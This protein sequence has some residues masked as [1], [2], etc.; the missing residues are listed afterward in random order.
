MHLN[1]ELPRYAGTLVSA[2]Q[3]ARVITEPWTE[4][5][6][7]CPSCGLSLLPYPTNTR[8]RDFY[9][10]TCGETFQQK[11][12]KHHFS[13]SIL[14]SEYKTTL[15][16]ILSDIHPSLILLHYDRVK[17]SVEDLSLIH[18][19]CIT[20]SCIIPRKPLSD[21]ARRAG[22]QG[23]TI[24][25]ERIPQVGRI[26]VIDQ[27][28]VRKKSEVLEQWKRS[29]A[30]LKARPEMRGWI[31]DVLRCV[32]KCFT[33]FSL[34]N[35]Y[36][37]EQELAAKHPNNKNVRAKIRQQLQVLRDLDFVEFLGSGEYRYVNAKPAP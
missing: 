6:F 13:K 37:F 12:S 27:G 35:V 3:I 21:M 28:H 31:A 19:A 7:Y 33:T 32:E 23:C 10:P 8:V 36:E 25:T 4:R 11:A 2:S 20:P 5:N 1:L 29:E 16:S 14:G 9:S 22:W 34:S 15:D 17:W 18:R 30:L 26:K 24:S